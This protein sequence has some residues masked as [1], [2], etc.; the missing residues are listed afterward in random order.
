MVGEQCYLV[1][2]YLTLR[3]MKE[4]NLARLVGIYPTSLMTLTWRYKVNKY[5]TFFAKTSVE[6]SIQQLSM[7]MKDNVVPWAALWFAAKL[8]NYI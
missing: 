6:V 1:F 4:K 2:A 3:C 5:D 7:L 8:C